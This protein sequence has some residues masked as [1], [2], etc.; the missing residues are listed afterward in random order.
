MPDNA[1]TVEPSWLVRTLRWMRALTVVEQPQEHTAGEDWAGD[2]APAPGMDSK[3]SMAAMSEFPWLF[4]GLQI[5]VADLAALPRQVVRGKG[6]D[7]APVEDHPFLDLVSTPNTHESGVLFWRQRWADY[8]LDGNA[9]SLVLQQGSLVSL[10]RLHPARTSPVPNKGGWAQFYE[11]N[12]QIRYQAE[13][14]LHLRSISWEDDPSSLYGQGIIRAA[15][16]DLNTELAAV[17]RAEISNKLGRPDVLVQPPDGRTWSP[18]QVKKISNQFKS[19][20]SSNDGGAMVMGGTSEVEQ[21]SWSPRDLENMAQ[22][23]YTRETLGALL[24]VPPGQWGLPTANYAQTAQMDATYWKH[25]ESDAALADSVDSKLAERLGKPGDRVV[26]D[27]SGVR[28]LQE[29]RTARLTR[30]QTHFFLGGLGLSE[31][32]AVEGFD[33][34]DIP[35]EEEAIAADKVLNGAQIKGAVEIVQLVAAGELPRDSGIG[36]MVVGLGIDEATATTIMAEAGAGFVPVSQQQT[37]D[38]G[39]GEPQGDLERFLRGGGPLPTPQTDEQRAA[40]WRQQATT[41]LAPLEMLLRGTMQAFLVRQRKRYAARI[42]QVL[43]SGRSAGGSQPASH[44]RATEAEIAQILAEVEESDL[45]RAAMGP[46]IQEALERAFKQIAERMG[47]DLEAGDLDASKMVLEMSAQVQ[48]TTGDAVTEILRA[49]TIGGKTPAQMAS[50]LQ[51]AAAFTPARALRIARTEST[52]AAAQGSQ[53]AAKAAQDQGVTVRGMM[54]ITSRD[55]HVR[56]SHVSLDGDVAPL[57]EEFRA[58]NGRTAK[59]P[60]QFGIASE[61]ANC[62][63]VLIPD[64]E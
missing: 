28:E 61:D 5:V 54:W 17:K 62:R 33:D 23:G 49:G 47:I 15:R 63:C 24:G 20:L 34:V 59:G 50:D 57:G 27:F 45:L 4:A 43:G 37:Q 22:R 58:D 8:L 9:Y 31:S 48:G 55:G 29:D 60:G 44:Q 46:R 38:S 39:Q 56:S 11:Y 30:V 64:V 52:R 25:R 10:A 1:L 2:F 3:T 36:L 7:A 6:A 35:E 19:W 18:P 51:R 26:T 41:L 13:D 53:Q 12:D 14:I 21:L 40:L 32:Y 16:R 42:V